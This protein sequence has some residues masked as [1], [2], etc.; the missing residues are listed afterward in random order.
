MQH[1]LTGLHKT[2]AHNLQGA[3]ELYLRAEIQVRCRDLIQVSLNTYLGNM[4]PLSYICP[5]VLDPL[6][7]TMVLEGTGNFSSL[8][9]DLLLGGKTD[10]ATERST[11]S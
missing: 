1:L 4:L 10:T 6:P 8:I 7:H 5:I 11:L 3:L 2:L 9:I